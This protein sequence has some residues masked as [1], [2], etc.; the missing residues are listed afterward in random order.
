MIEI[1]KLIIAVVIPIFFIFCLFS[2]VV[3]GTNAVNKAPIIG[4]INNNCNILEDD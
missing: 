1:K 2:T 4:M 3:S